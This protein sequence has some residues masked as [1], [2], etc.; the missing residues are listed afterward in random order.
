MKK[1]NIYVL[2]DDISFR[3]CTLFNGRNDIYGNCTNSIEREENWNIYHYCN[4]NGLHFHCTKHP[5]I[6]LDKVKYSDEEHKFDNHGKDIL[7]CPKCKK[8]I[9]IDNYKQ[10]ERQCLKMLNR[11]EFKGAKL[12]RLDD[13]YIQEIKKK[14]ENVP[15]KYWIKTE[16]K[17]DRDGDTIII[18]YVGYTDS[19]EKIQFF[20][21]PEKCQL[22]SDHNDLDPKEILSK[23]E[24][25][26]ND[27]TLSQEYGEN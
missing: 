17:T 23:I 8:E 20:I 1:E 14:I 16:V 13:W 21:K 6:E 22:T 27:R 12:I 9:T 15:S 18:I 2:N 11:E 24:V 26:L 7:K 10:L 4:Q 3:K 5:E 19:K 25:T